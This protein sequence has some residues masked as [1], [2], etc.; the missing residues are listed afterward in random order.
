M[1]VQGITVGRMCTRS[2][3]QRRCLRCRGSAQGR[4]RCSH[5]PWALW[6]ISTAAP[7]LAPSIRMR[8]GIQNPRPSESLNTQGHSPHPPAP[9]TLGPVSP[10]KGGQNPQIPPAAPGKTSFNKPGP[11]SLHPLPQMPQIPG[12]RSAGA[13]D[14]LCPLEKQ[15]ASLSH[16]GGPW[17][18]PALSLFSP[19][20]AAVSQTT[21]P[22]RDQ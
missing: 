3:A 13:P 16:S 4:S 22:C 18:A 6:G 7:W 15:Y 8:P 20:Q 21:V 10:A 14:V 17:P 2:G 5:C 9:G 19:H 1:G 12:R 11:S